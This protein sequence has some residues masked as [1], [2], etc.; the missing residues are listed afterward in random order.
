LSS[1]LKGYFNSNLGGTLD[2]NLEEKRRVRRELVALGISP[3]WS[4][5]VARFGF[6]GEVA[7]AMLRVLESPGRCHAGWFRESEI[8]VRRAGLD[9]TALSYPVIKATVDSWRAERK[10]VGKPIPDMAR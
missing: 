3:M 5:F 9:L 1:F 8:A 10:D 6:S 2:P 4:A 7:E